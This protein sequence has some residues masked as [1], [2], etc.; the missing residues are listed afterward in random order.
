[1]AQ[2]T[3][4]LSDRDRVGGNYPPP[5]ETLVEQL[6]RDYEAVDKT[7]DALA[8]RANG[9]PAAITNDN[10]HKIVAELVRD[11]AGSL[12][13]IESQR[14]AEKA[15]F[16]SAERAVDGFFKK[17]ETRLEKVKLAM[18]KR[19]KDFL[20]AKAAAE[21][22]ARE[23]EARV[24]REAQERAFKEAQAAEAAKNEPGVNAALT[25]AARAEDRAA[26]ADAAAAAKPAELARTRTDTGVLSTL[27]TDWTHAI[28]KYDAI[29]LDLLR[30]YFTRAEVDKAI[31]GFV[32]AGGRELT[33][34]RIFED[35]TAVTR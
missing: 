18:N 25:S 26:E 11:V 1:M 7:V 34:V 17:F 16:M 20:D 15:P 28:E 35:T 27:R 23:E 30:P 29:P 24:A 32:K 14:V 6:A 2:Q 31:R 19:I 33:G 3:P 12:K 8:A 22:R 4:A 21:R 13:N 5:S 9:A 10:E